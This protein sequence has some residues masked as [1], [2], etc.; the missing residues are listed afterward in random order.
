VA[1][2]C[3]ISFWGADVI[4]GLLVNWM[5][6]CS[7]WRYGTKICVVAVEETSPSPSSIS[8]AEPASASL[9]FFDFWFDRSLSCDFA[10]RIGKHLMKLALVS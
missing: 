7:N 5:W 1:L 9:Q 10:I 8:S 2:Q 4:P 3:N 6:C